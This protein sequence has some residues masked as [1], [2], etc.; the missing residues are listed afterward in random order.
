MNRI[1]QLFKS[2]TQKPLLL[3]GAMGSLLNE[4]GITPHKLLWMSHANIF[5]PDHVKNVHSEYISAGADIIT[6]NT[7]RTNPAALINSEFST[8]ELVKSAVNIAKEASYGMPGILIAGSNAP[9]E[10]CYQAERTLIK[11][12]L[13]DNHHRHIDMLRNSGCDFILNETQSHLDEINII[14]RYCEDND[15]PYVISLFFTNDL[16]ILSGE[17][18]Q[19]I[20]EFLKC[21]EPLAIS[22]NCVNPSVFNE[23][24]KRYKPDYKWGFYLNL[25]SGSYT[26]EN[27]VCSINEAAYL[28]D[29]KQYLAYNPSFIGACCGSNP[30]HIK[31][32]KEYLDELYRN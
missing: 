27:I 17:D 9:A 3:D 18:L 21:F 6:T 32:I 29:I 28:E 15:I 4:K 7:F 2:E 14:C 8:K 16:K 23:A 19:D 11:D 25:G 31:V 12:I 24:L 20:I 22:F 5:F 1:K 13:I 30:G 26:D 10:D